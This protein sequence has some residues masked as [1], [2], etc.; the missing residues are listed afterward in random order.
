[1]NQSEINQDNHFYTHTSMGT[2][3][4]FR[5]QSH[6]DGKHDNNHKYTY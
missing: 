5:N 2:G 1:M 6:N 4:D 3:T